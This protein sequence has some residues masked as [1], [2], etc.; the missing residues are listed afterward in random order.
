MLRKFALVI[1]AV[2]SLGVATLTP[3]PASVWRGGWHGGWHGGGWGWRGGWGPGW[4]AGWGPLG[5]LDGDGVAVGDGADHVSSWRRD[6][7]EAD[8][9]SGVLS[10]ARGDRVG[11]S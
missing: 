10:L 3:T 5:D 4:R 1:I 8:V 2:S 11:F 6:F 9:S 7:T